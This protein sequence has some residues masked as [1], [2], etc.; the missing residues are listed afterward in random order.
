MSYSQVVEDWGTVAVTAIAAVLLLGIVW[1]WLR[2]DNSLASSNGSSRSSSDSTIETHKLGE[3]LCSS[4]NCVRCRN[5][6]TSVASLKEQLLSKCYNYFMSVHNVPAEEVHKYIERQYPRVISTVNSI[7]S[8]YDILRNVYKESGYKTELAESQPHIWMMPG[9]KRIPFWNVEDDPVL[10]QTV[11]LFEGSETLSIIQKEYSNICDQQSGWKVNSIPTGQWRVYPLYNQ[12]TK[13]MDNCSCCPQTVQM[14]ESLT[15]FMHCVYGNAMF[16]VLEPA[17]YIEPHTGPCNFRLRCHIPLVAPE[18]WVI[19]VGM[20]TRAW[21]E[22]EI[23]LFDDSFVHTVRQE[24][25]GQSDTTA[26][27][28]VLLIFDIWHPAV[29]ESEQHILTNVFEA[30]S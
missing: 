28:R 22:G 25:D 17:S 21:R 18:G 4:P 16:S 14:I 30:S 12:G 9:L 1:K 26:R 3:S 24:D 7:E 23:M 27:E 8:K 29:K 10:K 6:G 2:R 5:L 15:N 11:D 13:V 20:E 19:Q